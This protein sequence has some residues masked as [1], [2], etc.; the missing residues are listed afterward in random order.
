MSFFSRMFIGTDREFGGIEMDAVLVEQY[1]MSSTPTEHPVDKKSDITDHIIRQPKGYLIQGVVTDTPMGLLDA[2][3]QIG[4][5]ATAAINFI[6]ENLLDDTPVTTPTSRSNAAFQAL[7]ALWQD[8]ILFDVQTGMGLYPDMAILNIQVTVDQ[9]T[10]GCL[11]F[12]ARLRH[13]SRVS[14]L[15]VGDPATTTDNLE[16]GTLKEGAEPIKKEGL[17]QKVTKIAD[18]IENSVRGFFS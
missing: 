4:E 1:E 18:S 6:R 11:N 16:E 15:T 17:K 9:N 7:V 5:T 2:L 14:L 10:A 13:I 12:A 8:G 3:S